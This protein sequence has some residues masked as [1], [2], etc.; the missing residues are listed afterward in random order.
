MAGTVE[1]HLAVEALPDG[2][3]TWTIWRAG[4][5]PRLARY[6]TAKTAQEAMQVAEQPAQ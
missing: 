6:G 5:P 4:D 2:S 3:W 1:F